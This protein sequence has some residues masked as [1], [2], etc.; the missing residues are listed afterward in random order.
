MVAVLH[1]LDGGSEELPKLVQVV[2]LV[3][4]QDVVIDD[5]SNGDSHR[6]PKLFLQLTA[7]IETTGFRDGPR[8]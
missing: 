1:R 6:F 8:K 7:A 5:A 3:G 2:F 4:C